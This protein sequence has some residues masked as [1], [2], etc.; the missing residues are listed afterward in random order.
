MKKA[1]EVWALLDFAVKIEYY[2]L[3][4]LT[5]FFIWGDLKVA[6]KNEFK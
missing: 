3:F 1:N 2:L 6:I 5:T 4:C